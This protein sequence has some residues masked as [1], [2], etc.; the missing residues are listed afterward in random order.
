MKKTIQTL[1]SKSKNQSH[2]V[3]MSVPIV[4]F[5]YTSVKTALMQKSRLRSCSNVWPSRHHLFQLRLCICQQ[6]KAKPHATHITRH[7]RGRRAYRILK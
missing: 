7:G 4:N 2:Y 6:D 5:K 3:A 1:I